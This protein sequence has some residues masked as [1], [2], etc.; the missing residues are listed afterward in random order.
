[1]GRREVINLP[2]RWDKNLGSRLPP[3]SGCGHCR[4]CWTKRLRCG[5][6]GMNSEAIRSATHI[7]IEPTALHIWRE[8]I[9]ICGLRHWRSRNSVLLCD[10]CGDMRISFLILPIFCLIL[11]KSANSKHSEVFSCS[12]F[13]GKE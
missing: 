2:I 6:T 13:P 10:T 11:S 5:L 12:L 8:A 7:A 1:M 9:S 3:S 4:V